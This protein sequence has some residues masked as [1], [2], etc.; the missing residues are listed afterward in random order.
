[1]GR[2]VR[3]PTVRALEAAHGGMRPPRDSGNESAH[4]VR[5]IRKWLQRAAGAAARGAWPVAFATAFA[6]T[7]AAR[8]NM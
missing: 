6:I 4:G 1:M 3:T 2:Y 8:D 5:V 7:H